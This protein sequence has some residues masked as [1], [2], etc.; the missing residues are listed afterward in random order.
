MAESLKL[1]Q[2]EKD[3]HLKDLKESMAESLKLTQK[4]TDER[5]KDLKESMAESLKLAQK[6]KD[7][8][9]K[10]LVPPS[11]PPHPPRLHI[12]SHLYSVKVL[13]DHLYKPSGRA[14]WSRNPPA[15]G[16]TQAIGR[17]SK[18]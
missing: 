8:R 17:H 2:K 15:S 10:D 1:A 6:G 14:I 7:E 16:R 11:L 4:E 5:L 9:L 12:A 18:V 13:S 3:E